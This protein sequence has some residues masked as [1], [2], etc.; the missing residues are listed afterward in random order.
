MLDHYLYTAFAANR[1]GDPARDPVTNLT[2][3]QPGV[4]PEPLADHDGA[5]GWL[6]AEHRVLVRLI[7]GPARAGHDTHVWQ[8]GWAVSNFLIRRGNQAD[9]VALQQ[10]AID[11]GERLDDP[12]VQARARCNL[13]NAYTWQDRSDEQLR[14]ALDLSRRSRNRLLQAHIEYTLAHLAERRG[15]LEA[16]GVPLLGRGCDLGVVQSC[17]A[18]ALNMNAFKPPGTVP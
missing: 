14:Q 16:C 9:Y 18:M 6:E 5:L 4:V 11:A 13:A 12:D 8:L 1:L 10:A 3:P 7:V 2:A 15:D 17:P